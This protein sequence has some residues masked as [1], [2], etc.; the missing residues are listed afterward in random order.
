M[1]YEK[2]RIV[3]YLNT[4][5]FYIRD[6]RIPGF[7][8]PWGSWNHSSCVPREYCVRVLAMFRAFFLCL[9][10][11]K[12]AFMLPHCNNTAIQG[13]LLLL[14]ILMSQ[15]PLFFFLPIA[16]GYIIWDIIISIPY[17]HPQCNLTLR[18]PVWE[19]HLFYKQYNSVL[20]M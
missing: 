15:I 6:L 3:L 14:C 12:G 11:T 18:F 4:M 19:V 9:Y 20:T 1:K 8:W 5:P 7:W 10:G 2:M 17:Y 13:H 16:L